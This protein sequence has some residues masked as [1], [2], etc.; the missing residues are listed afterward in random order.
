MRHGCLDL[1]TKVRT[2]RPHRGSASLPKRGPLNLSSE[3]QIDGRSLPRMCTCICRAVCFD[4]GS[5]QP[6]LTDD[7][8]HMV[9]IQIFQAVLLALDQNLSG[10]WTASFVDTASIERLMVHARALCNSALG[11]ALNSLVDVRW[12]SLSGLGAAWRTIGMWLTGW[13][14]MTGVSTNLCRCC[15]LD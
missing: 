9:E 2:S 15:L 12:G 3:R 13:E 6:H 14:K 10:F 7:L 4:Q 11:L 8:L 5:N 1:C